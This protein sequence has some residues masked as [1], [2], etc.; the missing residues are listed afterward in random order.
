MQHFPVERVPI[1]VLT[2]NAVAATTIDLLDRV[3]FY[4]SGM[5]PEAVEIIERELQSRGVTDEQVQE[6]R[7][8]LEQE[9]LWMEPGLAWRCSYCDRPAVAWEKDWFRLGGLVPI[10]PREVRCCRMHREGGE[11]STRR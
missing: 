11:A 3:T 4:R 2:A 9:V 10:F 5:M 6:H 1:D 7:A 8:Q